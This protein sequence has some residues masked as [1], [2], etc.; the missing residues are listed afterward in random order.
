MP[1]SSRDT[2]AFGVGLHAACCNVAPGLKTI[3]MLSG[4]ERAR[5]HHL[6]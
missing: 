2:A 5:Y 4:L 1:G 6:N 3:E